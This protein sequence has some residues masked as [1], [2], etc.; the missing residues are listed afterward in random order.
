MR[1]GLI[2]HKRI[3][4]S[5]PEETVRLLD[6]VAEKRDRSGLIDRAIKHYIERRRRANLRRQLKEGYQRRSG[7]DVRLAEEWFPLEQQV[8]NAGEK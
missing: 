8:W 5:L 7:I 6:R 3:N 4:I 2:M 1:K